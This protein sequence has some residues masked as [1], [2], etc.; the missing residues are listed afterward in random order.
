MMMTNP[1]A[2]HCPPLEPGALL[3]TSFLSGATLGW[4]AP[5]ASAQ[6]HRY[7]EDGL[8]DNDEDG[9]G[10]DGEDGGGDDDEDGGGHQKIF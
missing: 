6:G 10:D 8:G 3:P 2:D 9:G 4:S 7:D 1:N 5:A